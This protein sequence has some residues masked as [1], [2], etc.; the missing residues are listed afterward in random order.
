MGCTPK[1]YKACACPTSRSKKGPRV[2]NRDINGLMDG[3]AYTSEAKSWSNTP[4][5]AAD[6]RQDMMAV[7]PRVKGRLP[8]T[9]E[10]TSGGFICYQQNQ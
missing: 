6:S 8:I 9:G 1:A 2:G 5:C 3:G 10:L 7:S 4:S